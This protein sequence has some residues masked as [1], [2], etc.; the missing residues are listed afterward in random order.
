MNRPFFVFLAIATVLCLGT[1]ATAFGQ[2]D[3]EVREK[4]KNLKNEYNDSQIKQQIIKEAAQ[5]KPR[6]MPGASSRRRS[7]ATTG[8]DYTQVK[9]FSLKPYRDRIDQLFKK[10]ADLGLIEDQYRLDGPFSVPG[11]RSPGNTAMRNV[12]IYYVEATP[13]EM[14]T[15]NVNP[16]DIVEIRVVKD[17]TTPPDDLEAGEGGDDNVMLD[18]GA[19][20]ET[21]PKPYTLAGADLWTVIKL[22]DEALYEDILA[23]RAQEPSIPLPADL[24]LPEKRGPFL[25]QSDRELETSKG[26][27]VEFW[28]RIDTLRSAE[29]PDQK[30]GAGPFFTSSVPVL[31]PETQ[32]LRLRNSEKEAVT[33]TGIAFEGGER[34]PFVLKDIKLPITLAPKG[35]EKDKAEVE[36]ELR[37]NTPYETKGVLT[38]QAKERNLSQRID[39][40]AN[41]GSFPSDFVIIDASL[42]RIELRS[43]SRSAFAPSWKLFYKVGNDEVNLPRWASGISSLNIGYKNDMSVGVVLPNEMDAGSLPSPLAYKNATFASPMG[44]NI[45]FDFTFGFPFSLGGNLTIVNDFNFDDPYSH[46]SVLQEKIGTIDYKNDFFHIGSIGQV[47]YPIMFKDR[48]TDPNFAFRLN[49]GGGYMQIKRDHLVYAENAAN[50]WRDGKYE[51]EGRIFTKD[52][53]NTMVTFGKEKEIVDVYF[54]ISFINMASVNNYGIGLQYFGGSMMADAWLELTDWF[55]VEMKYSFLLREKEVWE[56]ESTYFLVT[57]RFRIGIPSIFN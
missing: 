2:Q 17:E 24:F 48:S 23:R 51:K 43:P 12:E 5:D 38:V 35:D 39:V 1:G 4:Q 41:P 45:A 32:K 46:L 21:V 22:V 6:A 31:F 55:R 29:R 18:A 30:E 10:A 33:L 25:V 27:F 50:V 11:K 40:I 3:S 8:Y 15:Q 44:Y 34:S 42:D 49:I 57:P 14:E 52:N 19:S 37:T 20:G 26:R 56:N 28:N 13:E 54:R 7:N 47:Y 16:F 36:F 9:G 53:A